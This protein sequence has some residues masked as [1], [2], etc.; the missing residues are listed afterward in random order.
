MKD[1][2]SASL[3]QKEQVI[4]SIK[5]SFVK[6]NPRVMI[7]NPIMFTVEV[8]T[9]IMFLVMLYSIVNDSQGSFIYNLWVFVILFITLLFANFAEA[10]AEAR[11]KAQAD[12]LRKTRE[13]TP[14]KLIVNGTLKTVS[15]SRLKKGDIFVCEAGDVIPADGEII[16]GLARVTPVLLQKGAYLR[17][18]GAL[19]LHRLR[20]RSGKLTGKSASQRRKAGGKT[21]LIADEAVG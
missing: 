9:A 3:F 12:S 13:E 5:Q 7:K 17:A 20:M 16:E 15:S 19:R 6:L 21:S 10:I 11:G 2:K 1:N 14:A 8:C 4:D 18:D